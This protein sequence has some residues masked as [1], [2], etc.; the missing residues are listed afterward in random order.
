M[1]EH[2]HV[3]R[4]LH[5]P[6]VIAAVGTAIPS[7]PAAI[8]AAATYWASDTTYAP[9]LK[10]NSTD[11]LLRLHPEIASRSDSLLNSAYRLSFSPRVHWK[12][13]FSSGTCLCYWSAALTLLFLPRIMHYKY[14][15]EQVAVSGLLLLVLAG[16]SLGFHADGSMKGWRYWADTPS[17]TWSLYAMVTPCCR[18]HHLRLK[19]RVVVRPRIRFERLP[20]DGRLRGALQSALLA[21][22][23]RHRKDSQHA[24]GPAAQPGRAGALAVR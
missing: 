7:L 14:M 12:D 8:Y 19:H 17:A 11:E 2:R 18:F 15:P 23:A 24:C 10:I 21:D 20:A 3:Y 6:H 5:T 1:P 9:D 13:P 16:G 4:R 22:S